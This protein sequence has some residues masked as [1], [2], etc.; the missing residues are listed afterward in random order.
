MLSLKYIRE[1]TDIVKESLQLKRSNIDISNLLDLDSQRRK[2][3]LQ[4]GDIFKF[5]PQ[6]RRRYPTQ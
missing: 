4:K 3:L 1:N 5:N 2:Y 6:N